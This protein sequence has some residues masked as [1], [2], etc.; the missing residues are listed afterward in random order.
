VYRILGSFR[1][2][3]EEFYLQ[4]TMGYKELHPRRQNYSILSVDSR[5]L[6]LTI[7]HEILS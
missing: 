1:D 5:I 4:D 2:D 7:I 6:N 3:Y